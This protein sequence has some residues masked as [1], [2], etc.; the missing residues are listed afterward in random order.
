MSEFIQLH[1]LVSYPP[2][3]LNRDDLG[4][5]KTAMMGE[6]QRLRISS[7]SLKRA[8][9]TSDVFSRYVGEYIGVRTKHLG[10]FIQ[11]SLE[12]GIPLVDLIF[13]DG[14]NATRAPLS[15]KDAS[16][17]AVKFVGLMKKGKVSAAKDGD[18][19]KEKDEES[20][21]SIDQLMHI[22][23]REISSIDGLLERITQGVKVSDDELEVFSPVQTLSL[24]HI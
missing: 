4:R 9:R 21:I 2:S 16:T 5:P 8:W 12:S 11:K 1:M 14:G 20:A 22:S 24:I 7:Q 10:G 13:N 6:K 17:W 23:P 15:P 19:K 18:E 3:N